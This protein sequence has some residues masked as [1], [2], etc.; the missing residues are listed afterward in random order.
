MF[1][2]AMGDAFEGG[3]TLYGPYHDNEFEDICHNLSIGAD[4]R[5]TCVFLEPPQEF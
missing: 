3:V 1:V 4:A 5:W 2:V